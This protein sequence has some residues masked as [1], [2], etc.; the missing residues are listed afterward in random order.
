MR[1]TSLHTM[2]GVTAVA[3][4]GSCAMATAAPLPPGSHTEKWIDLQAG[5]A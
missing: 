5:D 3:I 1:F 4:M 2:C